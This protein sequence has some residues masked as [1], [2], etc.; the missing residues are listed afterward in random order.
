[1]ILRNEC[2]EMMI[3]TPLSNFVQY[4]IY[5][6]PSILSSPKLQ[7]KPI[8]IA[9]SWWWS[10]SESPRFVYYNKPEQSASIKILDFGR[11]IVPALTLVVDK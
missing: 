2:L 4:M 9:K 5:L 10:S 11:T 1:M 7:R 6:L 3:V 8:L